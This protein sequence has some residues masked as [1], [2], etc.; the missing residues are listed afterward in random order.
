MAVTVAKRDGK[1][2]DW[3]VREGR[4]RLLE[5]SGRCG[6][7]PGPDQV[8]S[9][10]TA[11]H[12]EAAEQR[13]GADEYADEHAR[14]P[15]ASPGGRNPGRGPVRCCGTWPKV[16]RWTRRYGMYGRPRGVCWWRRTAVNWR[17]RSL[18]RGVVAASAPTIQRSTHPHSSITT[19]TVLKLDK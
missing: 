10:R 5:C 19:Q 11:G 13:P 17:N 8:Q 15:T 18:P 6:P 14:S 1:L 12:T 9:Q 3:R 16:P 7:I 2:D 4:S